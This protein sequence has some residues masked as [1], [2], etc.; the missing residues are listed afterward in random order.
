[1]RFLENISLY[2]LATFD[3]HTQNFQKT[4]FIMKIFKK[5]LNMGPFFEQNP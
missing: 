5:S 3:G 1:M 4:L 2:A